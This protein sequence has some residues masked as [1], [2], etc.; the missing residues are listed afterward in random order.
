MED[1]Q[2]LPGA[3]RQRSSSRPPP[4]ALRTSS[5]PDGNFSSR[6]GEL[7]SSAA[8]TDYSSTPAESNTV[9]S[10]TVP[11][12]TVPAAGSS[13]HVSAAGDNG[14]PQ[15]ATHECQVN[16]CGATQETSGRPLKTLDEDEK[17]LF[18][19]FILKYPVSIMCS[20]HYVNYLQVPTY[21][22]KC[23]NP[24]QKPK[25]NKHSRLQDIGINRLRN[26]AH[27]LPNINLKRPTSKVCDSC[28]LD[29]DKQIEEIISSVNSQ[30]SIE[31]EEHQ[32]QSQ[33]SLFA[34]SSGMMS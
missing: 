2:D 1:A 5:E 34:P 24:L 14:P 18:Q 15:L 31:S 7:S 11:A 21:S 17:F 10:A 28:I 3:K 20:S 22:K 26:I 16:G 30:I 4:S 6:C 9:P 19:Q 8:H 33:H 13:H 32:S 29:I 27:Y 23:T 12:A 25:H